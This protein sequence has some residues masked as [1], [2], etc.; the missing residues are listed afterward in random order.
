MSSSDQGAR[1]TAEGRVGQVWSKWRIDRLI[2]MGGMAAVFAATHRNGKRVAIKVLHPKIASNAAIRDRFLR[3]GYVANKVEHRG[4][5]QILDDDTTPD[6]APFLVMELLE[7]ESVEHWLA[8]SAGGRLPLPD[9]LAV[10]DQVL[11]TLAVFHAQGVIHRDIKPGNLFVTR[12]G[13]VKVLDFGLARL[14]EAGG[15][16]P[17][18]LAGTVLGTIE[19]MPPEQAAG[20]VDEVDARSDLFAV[21]AVMFRAITGA[22]FV[23]GKSPIERLRSSIKE[24]APPLASVVPGL[25]S[26][27]SD[28]VDT[29]L[30]FQKAQR[31]TDAGAM[32]VAVRAAHQALA[33]ATKKRPPLPASS[34]AR[35]ATSPIHPRG[36]GDGAAA[37][38][39]TGG[40]TI[41]KEEAVEPSIVVEVS[42][43]E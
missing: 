21:G 17:P 28:V 14:R 11:D 4:A 43:G 31:W 32:R 13:V 36:G 1:A 26:Y 33:A 15:T 38:G 25:P 12:D 37:S 24:A 8:R 34:R 10:A 19:Y 40:E 2:D 16:A 9:V 39:P 41:Y 27:F 35:D 30:A 23:R 18:T 29:A 5:V 7:G 42:F 6:G 20:K 3:E 22:T